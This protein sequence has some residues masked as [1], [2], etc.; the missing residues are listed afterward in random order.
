MIGKFPEVLN[1][2]RLLLKLNQFICN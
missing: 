1:F 2:N